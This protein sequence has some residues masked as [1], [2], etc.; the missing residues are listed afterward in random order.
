[1]IN[2]EPMN[3]S[4]SDLTYMCRNCGRIFIV[5]DLENKPSCCLNCKNKFEWE[6]KINV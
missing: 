3:L 2:N 6:E 1:M 5:L 4:D